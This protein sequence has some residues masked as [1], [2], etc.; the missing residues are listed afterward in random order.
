MP[1][2]QAKDPEPLR[3]IAGGSIDALS[4]LYDRDARDVWRALCCMLEAFSGIVERRSHW[5]SKRDARFGRDLEVLGRVL[6]GLGEGKRAV[7]VLVVVERLSAEEAA[8]AL[9]IPAATVRTRLFSARRELLSA[10]Q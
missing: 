8:K 9:S 7:F 3:R 10:L 1:T 4:G 2:N 6:A 5:H